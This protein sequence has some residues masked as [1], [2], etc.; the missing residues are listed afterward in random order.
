M[1]S[2]FFM[3]YR[4]SLPQS[5]HQYGLESARLHVVKSMYLRPKTERGPP[6]ATVKSP[7]SHVRR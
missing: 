1:M 4:M 3:G 6:S 2:H 7:E 5:L